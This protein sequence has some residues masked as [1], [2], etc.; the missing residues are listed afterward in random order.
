MNILFAVLFAAAA[1]TNIV[2]CGAGRQ[3][4]RKISKAFLMPLLAAVFLLHA[5]APEPWVVAALAFGWLG[6]L[7]LLNPNRDLLRT[8]GI[9]S[10][11]LGHV[12]YLAAMIR[13]YSISPALWARIA[14]PVFFVLAAAL[15]YTWMLA[16]LPKEMRL[17]GAVYYLALAVINIGA[18]LTTAS[19]NPGGLPLML[20]AVLFLV[21]DTILCR[22]FFT[23]GHPAPKHDVAVMTT[24]LVAQ[25]LI[26]TAFCL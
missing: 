9:A 24:Y 17:V 6:D 21:S 23:V 10:F 12:C 1:L 16:V 4:L 3:T 26:I 11:L 20:G 18:G 7:F 19:G 2:S 8:L 25:S 13:H 14:V 5:R 22:Q 15:I